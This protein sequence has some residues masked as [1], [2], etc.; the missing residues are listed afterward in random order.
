MRYKS[1]NKTLAQ[2]ARELHVD[3]IVEGSVMRDGNHLRITAQL[4]YVPT[5]THLW[6]ESYQRDLRDVLD[7]Q[8]ELALAIAGEIRV[9]LT[10]QEQAGLARIPSQNFAAHDAYLKGRYHLQQGTED[11]MRE[12]KAYFE[13]AVGI[14]SRYAPAYAGLADYYY[15]TNESPPRVAMPKA[16]EYVQ[17]ALAL[18]DRLPDAHATLASIRFYGNWDWPGAESEF[19]RAIELSPSYAEAR[20]TYSDFLSEMGRHDQALAEIRTAQ[21]LDPFAA[22]TILAGGWAFYYAREYHRA[23]EQCRTVLDL[24]SRSV[25]AR[26]CLGSAYLATAAYDQAIAEYSALVTS[27]GNDP[28][29]LASLG[30]AYALSGRKRPARRV[31]AQLTAASK[32]HYVP[33][34]FL[35]LIHAALGDKDESFSWLQRAY[36]QHDSYLVRLKVE[37]VIDPLRSDSR[38]RELLRR[39]NL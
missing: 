31:I 28:L 23:I 16:Y 39:M 1:T 9:K 17:K 13:E 25:S 32:I 38:Y 20:R 14:D 8:H 3:A 19:K 34:Y 30:C 10:A 29:R 24:D 27:S 4:I 35:G 2:I 33:P 5:D 7:V 37:P 11:Q 21:E 26:D 36:E 12:A 22:A 15:L 18:D 6:S